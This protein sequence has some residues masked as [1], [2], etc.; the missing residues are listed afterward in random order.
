MLNSSTV[1]KANLVHRV[2][3]MWLIIEMFLWRELILVFQ[4]RLPKVVLCCLF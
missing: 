1:I 2:P 4:F 3:E